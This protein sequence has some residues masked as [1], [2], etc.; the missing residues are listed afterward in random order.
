MYSNVH[1]LTRDLELS[2]MKL[3]LKSIRHDVSDPQLVPK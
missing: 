1:I 2:D 3:N